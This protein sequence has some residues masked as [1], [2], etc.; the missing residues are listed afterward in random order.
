MKVPEYNSHWSRDSEFITFFILE[1]SL[2]STWCRRIALNYQE[3]DGFLEKSF[4]TLANVKS[5]QMKVPDSRWHWSRDSE[6]IIFF[7]LEVS[8][9]LTRCR[10]NAPNYQLS[11][12]SVFRICVSIIIH[13]IGWFSMFRKYFFKF[14]VPQTQHWENQ[15][16]FCHIYYIV[17]EHIRR[18]NT[19]IK[20][21]LIFR[22]C[23]LKLSTLM[24][25]I[26]ILH[27]TFISFRGNLTPSPRLG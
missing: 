11:C 12:E 2:S 3:N 26:C 24:V 21:N 20:S 23:N 25:Y 19:P 27:N 5:V 8:L 16:L 1:V 17:R 14:L 22:H 9:S 6:F 13:G 7:I 15:V 4:Y 18:N 10:R